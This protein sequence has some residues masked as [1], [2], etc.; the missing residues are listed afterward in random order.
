MEQKNKILSKSG[1]WILR[2]VCGLPIIF[3]AIQMPIS[4]RFSSLTSSTYSLGGLFGLVG[5]AMFAM[6][7]ILSARLKIFEKF[8]N[9]MNEV[10]SAHHNLGAMAFCLLLFHPIL[11]LYS[12]LVIS[13]S[14]ALTFLVPSA[15]NMAQTYGTIGLFLMI[16]PL[17]V[18]FYV[19]LKYHVWKFTHKF[20]GVAFVFGFMHTFLIG[21]DIAINLYL[22]YYLF[23]LSIVAIVAYIY[24][25]ILGK[26]L[27]HKYEYK[28]KFIVRQIDNIWEIEFE[29]VGEKMQYKSGQFVF[30]KIQNPNLSSEAH[31]FS[32]SS[33]TG[34]NL[35]IAIKELGDY[36]KKIGL[37]EVGD[38][39]EIEGPYGTFSFENFG[40]NQVWIAGGVG[41]TPFLSM[42]RVLNKIQT[43]FNIDLYYSVKDEDG[44]A[45]KEEIEKI[46]NNNIKVNFWVSS[47]DGF[48]NA[49]SINKKTVNLKDR[50]ILICGPAIMMTSLK[51]Q[52]LE[53]GI[54]KDKIHT[55]DFKFY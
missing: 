2:I 4:L 13:F 36:T 19:K 38:K 3:W 7:L 12:Y 6:S 14:S 41:I 30:L 31:P 24:R 25:T 26:Y 48:I 28:V 51:K 18:T 29:P 37:V 16:L 55:E 40:K 27:V 44:L 54:R 43:S 35:K 46:S 33:A 34:D 47:K 45:F 1:F 53:I 49:N 10:Y 32:I 21:S 39:A 15:N 11:L 9:G 5:M 42:L 23:V 22:K 52:F 20:L 17:F 50:D 8:F